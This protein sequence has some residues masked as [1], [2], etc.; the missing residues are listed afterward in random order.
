MIGTEQLM[1]Y[2][3]AG[4]M[5]LCDFGADIPRCPDAQ[6]C[7][8]PGG[9]KLSYPRL[10]SY[11]IWST[12]SF[13]RDTLVSLFPEKSNLIKSVADPGEYGMENYYI[14]LAC[15]FIFVLHV[16]DD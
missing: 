4:Q 13:L 15:I 12:R 9:T 16:A 8:G 6:N 5:H 7:E 3:F 10:Y 1:M 2:P 14:R 11:D